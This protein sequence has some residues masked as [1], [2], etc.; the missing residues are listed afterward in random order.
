MRAR[1]RPAGRRQRR[2]VRLSKDAVADAVEQVRAIDFYI[3]KHEI[4]FDAILSL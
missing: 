1:G 2:R 3:P 4:I